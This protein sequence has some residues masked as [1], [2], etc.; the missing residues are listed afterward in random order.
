MHK[1]YINILGIILLWL[2]SL[3]SVYAVKAYPFPIT[4]TQ[5]DGTTIT[6]RLQ[7]D[8]FQHFHTTEDGYLLKRNVKGY[9]T[10]AAR[11]VAGKL[12]E[13]TT[14]A[15]DKK[16]R[17]AKDNSFIKTQALTAP[18]AISRVSSDLQPTRAPQA[19]AESQATQAFPKTGSPKSLVILV[20]FSDNS[21]SIPSPQT[22]YSNLLNQ[23]GYSA[24][25]GTGSAADYFKACTFG[26]F[27]PIFDVV[28]PFKLPQTLNYYGVNDASG[29]DTNPRQ[30]V[31]DACS[32]ANNSV[33][34]QDYDTDN[35]GIV[36][37][38]FIYYAGY[39]EA[40]YAPANT[41]WPHRWHLVNYASKFDLKSIYDYACTSE[42]RGSTGTNMC[43]IGTF[44]HEFGH[45]LGLPD[46]Y[47]TSEN[48]NTLKT[49]TIMDEGAYS[50]LGRTP[51]LYSAWDR[52]FLGYFT[53]EQKSA[54]SNLKLLPL[55]QGATT[56][57]NTNNQSF[58][59]SATN[60][61]LIGSAPSPA[62]FFMVEYRKKTG[63]DTYLPAEGMLIWHIDFLQSA[64]TANTP[65]DYGET[66][67]TPTDHMRVYLQPLSGT[68]T[69]PGTAFTTGD[70]SPTLW[71]GNDIK[72][73]LT[74]IT[75]TPDSINFKLMEPSVS[76]TGS[77]TSFVASVGT[78][79]STQSIILNAN[80]LVNNLNI[81]LQ[82]NTHY[83]IKLSTQST[84][85]KTLNL[86]PTSGVLNAIVDV[87]YNPL[88]AGVHPNLLGFSSVG[89]SPVSLNLSGTATNSPLIIAGNIKDILQFPAT[90]TNTV[91]TKTILIQTSDLTGD[92][93][94]S[95]SGTDA[96]L[97]NVSTSTVLK[98]NANAPAGS[99][100]SITYS[101]LTIGTHT[102]LMTLS[103]G[104]MAENRVIILNGTGQ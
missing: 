45:V 80:Y 51:P 5:P 20:E 104:G 4:E 93:T 77:F 2:S 49:W 94:I 60:H 87:R 70:F 40:E 41:V 72:R 10:Y 81:T 69:T 79:S 84:W 102:A 32:M 26:K 58:L 66:T 71:N 18:D 21:F 42:L 61:T 56:P 16:Y 27:S 46:Y 29:L 88:A 22:A 54:F 13:S 37:N 31:I 7:G 78:S 59:F 39:N 6:I 89:L 33:N 17:S 100:I 76:T 50:N 47:H 90:K 91:S 15:R 53:P 3:M 9:F 75:K 83:D 36:D 85:A 96:A 30:M 14:I 1:I 38:V 25:G 82:S 43:G 12:V 23:V 19:P 97:F 73:A 63:W 8:E 99:E 48:K 68:T 92:I 86:T 28:G 24:N 95:L 103:G 44:C 74:A 11:N 35:N 67:Q 55:Y 65:N 64:W 52:F 57:A 98:D 34:F 62:E 101:P